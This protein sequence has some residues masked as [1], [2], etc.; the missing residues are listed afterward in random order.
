MRG[1]RF[2]SPEDGIVSLFS[3]ARNTVKPPVLIAQPSR[4]SRYGRTAWMIRIA[5]CG[6]V[7]MGRRAELDQ[8][9]RLWLEADCRL[10]MRHVDRID[11]GRS[12]W[13]R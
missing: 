8:P 4:S 13:L 10:E 2:L 12:W 1:P 11:A 5:R 7:G 9:R 3:M 6:A